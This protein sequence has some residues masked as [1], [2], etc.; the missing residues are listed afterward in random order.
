[1]RPRPGRLANNLPGAA[2]NLPQRN[3]AR[4]ADNHGKPVDLQYGDTTLTINQE[5]RR[6][7]LNWDTFNIGAGYS[8]HFQQPIGGTAL[9][10]IWDTNPTVILGKLTATGEVIL[11]NTNGV[12]FGQ[13]ARV[14][15][16]R[17]WPQP[18]P[19]PKR[20]I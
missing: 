6:V 7:I 14:E 2:G 20:L 9:N 8:V 13:T 17:L 11:E 10:K 18:C 19:C 3:V 5:D 16:G 15:A 4:W 1:M 12:F